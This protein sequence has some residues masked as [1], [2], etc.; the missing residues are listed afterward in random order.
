M[1]RACPEAK[2]VGVDWVDQ[3]RYPFAFRIA[4]ALTYPLE[5]FDFIWA[6]PPCQRYCRVWRG[7][8]QRRPLYSD[9]IPAVRERLSVYPFTVIENVPGAPLRVDAVLTGSQFDLDIVRTRIFE[10][11]GFAVPFQ[12]VRQHARTVTSG[13]LA[14]VSGHG[15][16]NAWNLRRA[17]DRCKWRDL[18]D[19]LKRKL[20]ERNSVAGWRAA[21][22]ID[23]MSQKELSQAVPPA[24][25]FF[26]MKQFLASW[27][28]K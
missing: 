3:P 26:I 11:K 8:E 12:L 24:Y 23:W 19:D 22:G 5:G 7:Q 21:M 9:L 13:G 18:P 28:K 2:I 20:R 17:R 14:C 16:N 27:R 6:S 10:I 15:C 1:H 4:N 25:S